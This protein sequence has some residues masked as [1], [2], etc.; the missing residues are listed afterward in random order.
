[1]SDPR[2]LTPEQLD[3]WFEALRY[4]PNHS[5]SEQ[6]MRTHIAALEAEIAILSAQPASIWDA[7]AEY[8]SAQ[9]AEKMRI[10]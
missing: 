5:P 8:R 9:F 3:S 2:R 7:I 1:M 10:K 6:V 4:N